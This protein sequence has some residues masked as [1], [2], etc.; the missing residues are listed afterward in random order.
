MV[1]RSC[2]LL[3]DGV[4]GLSFSIFLPGSLEVPDM[5]ISVCEYDLMSYNDNSC[6]QVCSVEWLRGFGE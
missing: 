5:A 3:P 6:V 2:A 1:R 4:A